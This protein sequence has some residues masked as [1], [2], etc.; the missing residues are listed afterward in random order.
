MPIRDWEFVDTEDF[1]S[2]GQRGAN[3]IDGSLALA[4]G[5]LDSNCENWIILGDLTTLYNLNDFQVLRKLE[6]YKVRIIIVNNSGGRIFEKIFKE[7][8]EYFINEQNVS[9]GRV[10]NLWGIDYAKT[11]SEI[12]KANHIICELVVDPVKSSG[13]WTEFEELRL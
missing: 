4:L 8:K 10:A 3:G 9:F 2:L 1:H 6:D 12:E 7:N 5:Q 13:F 11:G